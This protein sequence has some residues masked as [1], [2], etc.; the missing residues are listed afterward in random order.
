MQRVATLPVHVLVF[1]LVVFA[2]IRA[3]PGNPAISATG[4]FATK[5]QIHEIDAELGLTGSIL[6]QLSTF[7]HNVVT[8]HLGNSLSSGVPVVDSVG[9]LLPQTAELALM[10]LAGAL[11]FACFGAFMIV[12]RP[13]NAISRFMRVYGDNAGAIPEFCIGVVAIFVFYAKLHW[14]PPPFG[15]ISANLVEPKPLTHLPFLDSIL[16]GDFT[17]TLSMAEHLA[18]PIAVMILGHSP[19]LLKVLTTSLGQALDAPVTK[20]R[21]S[22]GCSR[23]IVVLSMFRRAA[24]PVVT[25]LGT[26][27]GALLG[28]AIII[29]QLFGFGGIGQFIVSSAQNDDVVAIQGFLLIMAAVAL[30]VF[31]VVDIVNMLI[32]PRRRPGAA[33]AP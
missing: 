4:G 22:V 17:V 7:L 3:I 24:P 12:T 5:A 28:G 8:L 10:A 2:V 1:S 27:F 32:D 31:L 23:R 16:R 29:E 33:V 30:V 13:N 6:H 19:I 14:T 15:R 21:T 18:L 25:L 20:F 9:D 26:L 11:L